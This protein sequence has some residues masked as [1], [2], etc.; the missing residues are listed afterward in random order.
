MDTASEEGV[1]VD[2]FVLRDNA[3][4]PLAQVDTAAV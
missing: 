3:V 1:I 2:N 4:A